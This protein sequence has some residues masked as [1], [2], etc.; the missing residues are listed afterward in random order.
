MEKENKSIWIISVIV[1]GGL[2]LISFFT[3]NFG[4]N[5]VTGG[6]TK[7]S[8]ESKVRDFIYTL[9]PSD[10]DVKILDIKEE[11]GMYKVAVFVDNEEMSVYISKDS[12]LIF[13]NTFELDSGKELEKSLIN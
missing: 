5:E 6:T 7:E 2:L 11:N 9:V 3:S 1:L 12:E 4:I 13:L 8:I 10:V